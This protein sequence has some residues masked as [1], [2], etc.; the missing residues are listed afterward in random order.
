MKTTRKEKRLLK[1]RFKELGVR[2]NIPYYEPIESKTTYEF[3]SLDPNDRTWTFYV[4]N[5][6]D[7]KQPVILFG[8]IKNFVSKNVKIEVFE[9]S[10]ETVKKELLFVTHFIKGM[11]YSVQTV[12]QLGNPLFLTEENS[13]GGLF[14]RAW[15]PMNYRSAQNNISCQIDAPRFTFIAKGNTYIKFDINP[16]EKVSFTFSICMKIMHD[17]IFVSRIKAPTGIPQIDL[18]DE[19]RKAY[20]IRIPIW[21]WIKKILKKIPKIRI[22][23]K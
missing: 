1:K 20:V 4:T 21:N 14:S 8:S 15:Q 13:T 12:A 7:K 2:I 18:R 3:S 11:K 22:K 23:V 9:S 16:N 17:K 5:K 19:K 10:H 6:T